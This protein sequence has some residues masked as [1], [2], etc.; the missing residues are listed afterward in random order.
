MFFTHVRVLDVYHCRYA[1]QASSSCKRG[2]MMTFC[3]AVT[4][5]S[6]YYCSFPKKGAEVF[7][8]FLVHLQQ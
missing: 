2:S 3:E 6:R 8:P 1:L 7:D 5:A 4:H